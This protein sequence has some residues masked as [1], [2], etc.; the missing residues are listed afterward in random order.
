VLYFFIS[1]L[2]IVSAACKAALSIFIVN[3][4]KCFLS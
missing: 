2:G 1:K 3:T 4:T